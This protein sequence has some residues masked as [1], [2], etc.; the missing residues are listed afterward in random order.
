MGYF[1]L[2]P[3]AKLEYD[4]NEASI[5]NLLDFKRINYN[6]EKRDILLSILNTEI[7]DL[8][9]CDDEKKNIILELMD[10]GL[11]YLYNKSVANYEH[12]ARRD[13]EIRGL[14]EEVPHFSKIYFE[15]TNKCDRNCKFCNMEELIEGACNSCA[16]WR[17]DSTIHEEEFDYKKIMKRIS[18]LWVEEIVISGGNPFENKKLLMDYIIEIRK[19][20]PHI[21]ILIYINGDNLDDET[22]KFLSQNKVNLNFVFL[23][24]EYEI[25]EETSGIA[26]S[27]KDK[28][29]I[30]ECIGSGIK[31]SYTLL[32]EKV[33]EVEVDGEYNIVVRQKGKESNSKKFVNRKERINPNYMQNQ[34]YNSC[35]N[36]KLAITLDGLVRPCPMISDTLLDLKEEK[37][38]RLFQ[39]TLVDK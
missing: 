22:V 39:D 32:G 25:G 23:E 3:I 8:Q 1:T 29:K 35:L 30:K 10:N 12:K 6:K 2:L 7:G 15:I 9:E 33:Y 21:N 38:D 11:A 13:V 5:V 19:Y 31:C 14:C 34:R 26:L 18:Q 20:M 17:R 16:K 4:M 37:F 28:T 24:S 36:N 27:N